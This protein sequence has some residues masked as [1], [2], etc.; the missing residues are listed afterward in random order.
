MHCVDVEALVKENAALIAG[1]VTM[2]WRF[3]SDADNNLTWPVYGQTFGV[4][5]LSTDLSLARVGSDYLVSGDCIDLWPDPIDPS[6]S[7]ITTVDVIMWIEGRDSAGWSITGGGPNDAGG[8]SPIWSSDDTHNSGY[9]LVHE[10]ARFEITAVRMTPSSPEVGQSA[11]LE[12]S[13]RNSGTKAGNITLDIQ[14]VVDDGFPTSELL[15]TT[16]SIAIGGSPSVFI[17]LEKFTQPTS[18]MYFIIVDADTNE[19]L[20][21]GSDSGKAFNVKVASEESGLLDGMGMLIVVGLAALILILLVVVIVLV[22]RDGDEGTYEYEYDGDVEQKEYVDIPTATQSPPPSSSPAPAA[23]VDPLMASAMAEFP[24]W[25]QETI[26]G[27]FD[28]GWDLDSLRDWV[29]SNQ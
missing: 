1:E 17:N 16:D 28:Q 25:D 12:V 5:S 2:K 19:V 29:N 15:F 4:D 8:V 22:K 10:E 26:Q 27:Y 3:F 23:D 11:Q 7:Q 21:N 20:W 14:T 18:G 13:M 9:R 24:Q 6:Q